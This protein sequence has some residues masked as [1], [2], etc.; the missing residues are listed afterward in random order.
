MRTNKIAIAFLLMAAIPTLPLAGNAVGTPTLKPPPVALLGEGSAS[1]AAQ[2]AVMYINH[3]N[4]VIAKLARMNDLFVLQ[5]EYENLTDNN[6]NLT[7]IHDEL[8]VQ[9]I[10][11]LMDALKDLQKDN[12][13]I[14]KAQSDFER[15]KDAAIWS[16]LPQPAMFVAVVNP[17]TLAIAVGGAALTSVQNYQAAKARAKGKYND[18]LFKA[19]NSK[20]DHINEINKELFKAQ[21]RLMMKYGIHDKDRITRA[22]S[23]LFLG[24][25]EVLEGNADTRDDYSLNAVVR[26]IYANHEDEM[27]GLP[28]YW[29]TRASA[30]KMLDDLADIRYCCES[31]FKLYGT[32]PIIRRDMDACAMALLY[33]A[34]A[35]KEQEKK[36][37]IDPTWVRAWLH[38]IEDTVR[39]PEWSTKFC[40]AM[41]YR[42]IGDEI[43]AQEVLYKSFLEVYACIKVWEKSGRKKNIFRTTPALEKAYDTIANNDS[44]IKDGLPDW[45]VDAKRLVPYTGYVWLS[46]ALY[47]SGRT[48][49][50][51]KMKVDPSEAGVSINYITGKYKRHL[52]SIRKTGGDKFQVFLNGCA[53]SGSEKDSV[54]VY[55]PEGQI[56]SGTDPFTWPNATDDIYLTIRT[57]QGITAKFTFSKDSV[58][59]PVHDEICY[60]WSGEGK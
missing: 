9:L 8:T 29:I 43:K 25:A 49:I 23:E 12:M 2:S 53:E 17:V 39:T 47:K 15:E 48:D 55:G 10:M 6:L 45:D 28:F 32:T 36:S 51:D 41:L 1:N 7:T 16:A 22:D 18:K 58:S 60:P 13:A 24:F 54:A 27:G 34:T 3:L 11:E 35:M 37:T 33:V 56:S 14:L 50:Y 31:Y 19:G 57:K 21:W 52:P 30:S 44:K 46:G 20:L 5:Q 38:F 26:D 42:K 59:K 40:V 4:F